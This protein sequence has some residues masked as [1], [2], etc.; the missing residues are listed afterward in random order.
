MPTAGKAGTRL[1]NSNSAAENLA[2]SLLCVAKCH[3]WRHMWQSATKR[4]YSE[5]ASAVWHRAC[6]GRKSGM[7]FA[8][9]ATWHDVCYAR[10]SIYMMRPRLD[11]EANTD[12]ITDKRGLMRPQTLDFTRFFP[13]E[14]LNANQTVRGAPGTYLAIARA[15]PWPAGTAFASW[16]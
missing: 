9:A 14:R 16:P 4:T 11:L 6:C 12:K 3:M 13:R 15:M 7:M 5:N 10:G 8:T 2:Q 1:A